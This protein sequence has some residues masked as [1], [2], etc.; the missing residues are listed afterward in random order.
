[1]C[2]NTRGINIS[3]C[4]NS[5]AVG[6]AFTRFHTLHILYIYAECICVCVCGVECQWKVF[7]NFLAVAT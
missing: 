1:M 7:L 5:N 4:S 2:T 3:V 6:S